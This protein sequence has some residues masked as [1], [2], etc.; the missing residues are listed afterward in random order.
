[1]KWEDG[2]PKSEVNSRR[3][4]IHSRI[5]FVF[6]FLSAVLFLCSCNNSIEEVNQIVSRANVKIEKGKDVVIN[7]SDNGVV[8]IQAMGPT[9][10]RF[11]TE[12]PYLEFPDGFKILFYNNAHEI[13]ST[14]TSRTATAVENSHTMTARDSVVVVN[15][16]GE[17]LNT[18]ELIWDEEKKII[19]SNSFVKIST[20]DEI[21]YGNGMIAN[22]NFS[23][24]TIKHI[25]GVIKVKASELE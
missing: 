3:G 15:N 4:F 5:S 7:Y 12:K 20:A 9:A 6:L 1:M 24:Y 11:N 17:V 21:L 16:K 10:T 2:S 25:T 19:Y 13:E 14:L 22:E 8:R 18:D 23:D